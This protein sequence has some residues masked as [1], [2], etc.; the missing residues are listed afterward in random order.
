MQNIQRTG[1][2]VSQKN[3]IL[4]FL[5]TGSKISPAVAMGLCGCYRLA[6]VIHTLRHEDGYG[7]RITTHLV[8]NR[9]GNNY[10]EYSL[11]L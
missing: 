4:A 3:Q 5:K 1:N 9:N 10:A 2:R 11:S 8:K 6:A 7:T